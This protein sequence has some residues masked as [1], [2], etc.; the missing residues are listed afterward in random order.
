MSIEQWGVLA[1]VV[2]LPLLQGVAGLRRT[3]ASNG[4]PSD[5]VAQAPTSRRGL[6]LSDRDADDHVVRAAKQVA[7][8]PPSLPPP[9]PQPAAQPAISLSGLP[10]THASSSQGSGSF[11][12]YTRTQKPRA[13]DAV[14]QWLRP[15]RELRRA[16]V[17]AITALS[18]LSGAGARR[19]A[20]LAR[21]YE[22]SSSESRVIDR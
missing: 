1:L 21:S 9:L 11:E 13:G 20:H 18:V 12:P 16:I 3:R 19:E 10:A 14:V 4:G 7:I 6:P 17:V 8:P 15:V 5:R 2:L 22:H